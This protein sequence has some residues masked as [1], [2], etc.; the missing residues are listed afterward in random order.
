[1]GIFQT[2]LQ[3]GIDRGQL[4]GKT[5][6]A[7]N[8]YRE[9]AKDYG[10]RVRQSGPNSGRIDYG[11]VNENS[12]LKQNAQSLTTTIIPGNMYMYLYDPKFKDTLPFYDR[13]PLLFPFRVKSDRF[14]GINLHYID[15]RARAML[16]DALYEITNNKRYDETTRLKLSYKLLN[17]SARFKYFKPCVKQYLKSHV[18]SKFLYVNPEY[19]DQALFLPS[20]KFVKA[21]KSQVW[22]NSR[23]KF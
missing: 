2:I 9:A 20:E 18:E 22:S 10:A 19:W 21:T 14:W 6:N 12:L 5:Q 11:R 1:M 7:R 13:F 8:W 3:Q 17:E 23:N 15:L 16:M 4:P